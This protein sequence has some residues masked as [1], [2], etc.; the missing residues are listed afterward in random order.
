[1]DGGIAGR[2]R[3]G[4]CGELVRRTGGGVMPEEAS[5]WRVGEEEKRGSGGCGYGERRKE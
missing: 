2:R 5:E 3:C 4:F 1:M